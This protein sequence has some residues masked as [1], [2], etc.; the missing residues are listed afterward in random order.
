VGA[1]HQNGRA[2]KRIRDLQDLARTSLIQY[3]RRWPHA[4]DVRLWPYALR[5]AN[6]SLND[7]PFKGEALAPIEKFSLSTVAP[8]IN[9]HHLFGCPAYALDGRA[10]SGKK[11]PKWETRARLA[12]CIGPSLQHANSVG[13]VLSLTMGLVSPQFHIKYDDGFETLCHGAARIPSNWQSLAGF[14]ILKATKLKESSILPVAVHQQLDPA[15][16]EALEGD[17]E[18]EVLVIQDNLIANDDENSSI[19]SV[20][21]DESVDE[22]PIRSVT[23]SGRTVKA[24]IRFNDYVAHRCDLIMPL[25]EEDSKI[26]HKAFTASSDPD[27]MY[28]HQAM[29]APDRQQ[30]LDAMESEVKSHT[31]NVNWLIINK[32]DVPANHKILPAVWAMRRKRDIDTRNVYKWKARLN[33]HGGKQEHGINFWATYAPVA[34]WP[35]I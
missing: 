19:A 10:Q 32:N 20:E 27:V 11:S 15:I 14:E 5:H 29:S 4:V 24:P 22:Q 1:H 9:Q 2:E 18:N 3:H 23:R 16:I 28:L 7:T 6:Y 17:Q 26:I 30:F 35:T 21:S 33:I 34:S 13:L 12:I 25:E 8:N 31:D